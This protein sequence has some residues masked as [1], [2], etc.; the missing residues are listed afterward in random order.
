MK[1][2]LDLPAEALSE[3]CEL[4]GLKTKRAVVMAAL[5]EFIMVRRRQQLIDILGTVEFAM[6]P[7][8][9]EATRHTVNPDKEAAIERFR[10]DRGAV[11]A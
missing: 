9:F 2:T 4:S 10:S 6:T 3:A 1:T 11:D 8:E 5:D 7:A